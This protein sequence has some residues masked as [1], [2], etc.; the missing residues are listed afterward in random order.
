MDEHVL[1]HTLRI[2][3]INGRVLRYNI[4]AYRKEEIENWLQA[5]T[6]DLM[7]FSSDFISFYSC[8]NRMAFVRIAAIR[9][10]IFCW[11]AA[12]TVSD[13]GIPRTILKRPLHLKMNC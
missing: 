11:D 7:E 2:E 8:P 13:R 5:R 1:I 4:D 9:R 3:L 12:F 10:L 6:D